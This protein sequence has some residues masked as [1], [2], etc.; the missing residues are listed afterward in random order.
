[1]SLCIEKILLWRTEVSE[2]QKA[3]EAKKTCGKG[4]EKSGDS[5]ETGNNTSDN[6]PGFEGGRN[7]INKEGG[8]IRWKKRLYMIPK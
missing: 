3:E 8:Q 4:N 1:M 6:C 2:D 5:K 7:Q